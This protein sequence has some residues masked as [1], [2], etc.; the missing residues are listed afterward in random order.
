MPEDA[1]PAPFNV[2]MPM[3]RGFML[4]QALHAA[5][6]LSIF[7]GRERT[8]AEFTALYR[9]AGFKLARVIPTSALPIVE[10]V[11]A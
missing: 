7:T 11:P 9:A 10:G 8:E 3:V 4:S 1:K 6:R 5:A 2:N